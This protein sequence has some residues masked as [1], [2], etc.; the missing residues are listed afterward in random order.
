[1]TEGL[2]AFVCERAGHRCEYCHLP[3]SASPLPFVIDHIIWRQHGGSSLADNCALC[4]GFCNSSKGPNI[5]GIDPVTRAIVA[6]FHPRRTDGMSTLFGTVLS[7]AVS[8]R[9]HRRR[10]RCSQ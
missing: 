5:A 6:L 8:Q 4:C 9:L 7:F 2:T 3:E 1:M 10:L